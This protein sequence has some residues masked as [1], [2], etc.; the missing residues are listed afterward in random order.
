[1]N[2]GQSIKSGIVPE[3]DK[4]QRLDAALSGLITDLSRERIKTLIISE[5]LLID[6]VICKNPSSKTCAGKNFAL[7]VPVAVEGPAKAQDIPLDVVFE[8]THL[9]V[10]NKPAGLVVHPA[11]GH[12]DGTLV[13]ALLHHCKGE[14]SGI[15]GVMRPG[16]VHRIDKDTSGL[17]V[18]AK[19][20]AAH[21]G[22]SAL[23]A[24]H[25]IDRKYLAIV[26]GR[27]NPVSATIEGNIGRSNVHRKKMAVVGDDKGKPA[28]THYTVKE[29]LNNSALVECVLETGRTHQVRVHMSHIGYSLIGD[30]LYGSRRK[31]LVSRRKDI[32]FG[33]QA[34][35]AAIL[36]FVHPI[37]EEKLLFSIDLP[38][39]MQELF[40][41]LRV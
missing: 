4:K 29:A 30:P 37:T 41:K 24:K 39:D 38:A 19:T 6:G 10:I 7:T 33:R 22:L 20:D 17:M 2:S 15:G 40:S 26:H 1:M 5:N 3:S 31:S 36:G 21:K 27:P 23:F 13:N 16:I 28:M 18:A 11:A 34:L 25:D 8:D 35:H 9:I 14:L 12:P 32:Q